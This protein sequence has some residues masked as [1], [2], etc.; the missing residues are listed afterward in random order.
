M[1]TRWRAYWSLHSWR[2]SVSLKAFLTHWV[3][4]F[5]I[6][7]TFTE[8]L[9]YFF[10]FNGE[11]VRPNVWLLLGL[12]IA[13][14]AWLS[15][16]RLT[17]SVVIP[18]KDMLLQITVDNLFRFQDYSL[19]IPSNSC[20]KHDHIDEGAVIVQFRNRFFSSPAQFDQALAQALRNVAS[21]QVMI[22]GRQV[23][24]YPIG[25]VA[26]INLPGASG[27]FAYVVAS[28]DLNE[29][30]RGVPRLDDLKAALPALWNHIGEQG[31]TIPLIMPVPGSGR[32]RLTSNRV[33]LIAMIVRSFL[34]GSRQRKC[35]NRLTIAIHPTAYLNN[36]YNLDD[37]DSYISFAAKYANL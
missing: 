37:I 9:G 21:E 17:R 24:K 35:T 12:G 16:P 22:D 33:E 2:N 28:C 15:R 11:P 30:G 18:E 27:R 7:W 10:S 8:F 23:G 5:A 4:V 29:H 20:F 1:M 36:H 32:Q 31:T 6:F 19:I 13:V 34:Q 26:M 14:A 25:T 3:A